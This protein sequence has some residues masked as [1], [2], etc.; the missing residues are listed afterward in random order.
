MKRLFVLLILFV[1]PILSFGKEYSFVLKCDYDDKKSSE[2]PF[3]FIGNNE[4]NSEIIYLKSN[5]KIFN[6]VGGENKILE[7]R[8]TTNDFYEYQH[9]QKETPDLLE[10]TN[11]YYLNRKTL[12]LSNE[13]NLN[14]KIRINFLCKYE[15]NQKKSYQDAINLKKKYLSGGGNKI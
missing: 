9:F 10:L 4:G 14:P 5:G 6:Y 11:F 2:N 15:S 8:K 13:T 12:V 7:L 1:M 3:Y